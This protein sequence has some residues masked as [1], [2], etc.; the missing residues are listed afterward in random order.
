MLML[1][2]KTTASRTP[3][4]SLPCFRQSA[5]HISVMS[6]GLSDPQSFLEESWGQFLSQGFR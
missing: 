6:I 5:E 4:A 1:S 2:S 3:P